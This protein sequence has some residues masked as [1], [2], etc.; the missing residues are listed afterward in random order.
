[1]KLYDIN[2]EIQNI[3]DLMDEAASQEDGDL[4]KFPLF[5][6]LEKL[7][8][9]KKEKL[10]SIACVIKGIEADIKAI[11]DEKKKLT[12][13]EFIAGNKLARVEAF[14]K[15]N[16]TEGEK[17]KDARASIGW[18]TS[19]STNVSIEADLLP[20]QYQR[21]NIEADKTAIKEALKAGE[22][23]V[24]CELVTKKSIVIN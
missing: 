23:I 24:G 1:M 19:T 12:Q 9:D 8:M 16:L 20:T 17:L 5:E 14:L 18:T 11:K 4:T 7:E 15:M 6:E 10:L 3:I 2:T 21:V 22:I 13:K